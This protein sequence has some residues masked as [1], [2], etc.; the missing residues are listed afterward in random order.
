MGYLTGYSLGERVR[1]VRRGDV[2]A[3]PRGIAHWWYNSG[4]QEM[5]IIAFADTSAGLKP[6][7]VTVSVHPQPRPEESNVVHAEFLATS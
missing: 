2:V 7:D 1:Q 6:G 4:N 3:F 5:R